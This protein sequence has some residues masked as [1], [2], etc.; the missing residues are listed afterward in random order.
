[1]HEKGDR[2]HTGHQESFHRRHHGAD[3]PRSASIPAATPTS[4][5]TMSPSLLGRPASNNATAPAASTHAATGRL[6]SPGA[7]MPMK[8]TT[9]A[10]SSPQL[11]GSG[12]A[13]PAMIPIQVQSCQLG[14]MKIAEPRKNQCLYG[15][16]S[17]W[18]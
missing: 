5:A 3:R 2:R 4:V 6:R 9:S 14:Y 11:A 7:S 15:E 16:S 17:G 12:S 8:V 13:W 1:A 10:K 18:R